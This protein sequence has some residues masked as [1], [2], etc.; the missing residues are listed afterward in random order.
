V[1][2]DG[3]GAKTNG[4]P[5]GQVVGGIAE[6][7]HDITTL[8]E[9]QFKLAFI[10]FK[11]CL[12]KALIPLALIIAGTLFLLGALPVAILGVAYLVATA[13]NLT[14]GA[15]M[16]LTG[17][18]VLLAAV[19]SLGIGILRISPTF[20]TFRRSREEFDRNLNWI[21]TVLLYSGRNVQRR[22]F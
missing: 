17:V 18:A 8:A 6:F 21:R 5:E 20:M 10:D 15:A 13:F 19:A 7:G 4:S 11:E 2:R 22:R 16:L 14:V 1:R 3:P 12:Q 9:L